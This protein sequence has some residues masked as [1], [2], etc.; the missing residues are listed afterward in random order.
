MSRL[1]N[2]VGKLCSIIPETKL[3][4][5]VSISKYPLFSFLFI[6]STYI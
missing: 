6:R 3:A 4:I 1:S 5:S 2:E